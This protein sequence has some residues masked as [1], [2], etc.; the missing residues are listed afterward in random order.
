MFLKLTI[1]HFKFQKGTN[2]D[3]IKSNK[4]FLSQYF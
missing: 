2:S 1:F 3:P 4:I